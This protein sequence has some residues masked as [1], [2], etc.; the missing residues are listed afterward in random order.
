MQYPNVADGES[1][2]YGTSSVNFTVPLD[3]EESYLLAVLNAN[4]QP[5]TATFSIEVSSAAEPGKHA[6]I[7]PAEAGLMKHC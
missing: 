6:G 1:T 2:W 4:A 7:A 3:R 5:I